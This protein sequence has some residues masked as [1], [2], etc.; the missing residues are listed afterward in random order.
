VA[1]LNVRVELDHTF[2]GDLVI[3]LYGPTGARTLLWSRS[4]GGTNDLNIVFD[5][6]GFP[7][8]CGSPSTTLPE[9]PLGNF[10]GET[11]S[12]TYTLTVEDRAGGDQGTLLGFSLIFGSES[13]SPILALFSGWPHISIRHDV[14]GSLN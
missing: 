5:D 11:L 14:T 9:T 2:L 12:G 3:Y 4:C 7:L 1:D 6:A 13:S 10:I 8:V